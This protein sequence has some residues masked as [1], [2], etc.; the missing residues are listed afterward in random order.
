MLETFI[1]M[2][3]QPKILK[4][5]FSYIREFNALQDERKE[6]KNF[7]NKS[8]VS[9]GISKFQTFLKMYF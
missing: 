5:K 8:W 9:W 2:I 6:K 3:P 4:Q 7:E 1:K